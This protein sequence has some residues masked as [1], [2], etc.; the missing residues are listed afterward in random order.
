MK[1]GASAPVVDVVSEETP[2]KGTFNRSNLDQSKQLLFFWLF[3]LGL[4]SPIFLYPRMHGFDKFSNGL[5][6]TSGDEVNV[7]F[8]RGIHSRNNF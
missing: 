6:V 1:D 3:R 2:F 4:V 7:G 5:P 8:F